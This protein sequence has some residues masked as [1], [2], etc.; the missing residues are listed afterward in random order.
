MSLPNHGANPHQLAKAL[1]IEL[2]QRVEDFSENTNPFGP[3]VVLLKMDQH[4]LVSTMKAYPDPHVTDLTKQLAE[5]N[6]VHMSNVLVGNGAAELIFLLASLFRKKRVKI[7]EPAFSEYRD[8]CVAF[9]CVVESVVLEEPWEL[10][11]EH[12][13]G[14]MEQ[15]DLLFLC[16]PNNP[17][18]ARYQKDIIVSLL[19]G[20][21][22]EKTYV[23]IDEAFYDF[24]EEQE[25]LQD[26]LHSFSYLILL[27]SMTKMYAIA[28]L[29][30][31]YVLA[32][33]KIISQ[34]KKL[35]PPWS[36]NGF[37]Q[38][39]GLSLLEED[40]FAR[41]SVAELH[42][43]RVRM[44]VALEQLDFDVA[45]S[46]VNFYLLSEKR[47]DDLVELFHFLAAHGVVVR[48]TYNFNGLNGKY[49]RI[50]VKGKESNDILLQ[51]VK[52]WRER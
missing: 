37:A 9:E 30:L 20:A 31:G 22:K 3:P 51:T 41:Q 24:C 6:D 32:S 27:R 42:T 34:L 1:G 13:S 29:R 39:V 11:E 28:G 5:N 45:P 15:T 4:E 43:E 17:T 21:E 47:K 40:S 10:G 36:V 23:V 25:G 18:G 46:A 12:L 19:K 14:L 2:P 50:A 7:I 44:K 52:K 49:L 38:K 33:E 48:H 8:A 16:S 26:L 35:Q